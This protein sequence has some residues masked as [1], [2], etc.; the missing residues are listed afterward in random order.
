MIPVA[1]IPTEPKREK[2]GTLRIDTIRSLW[3]VLE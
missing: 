3:V 1:G 2:R